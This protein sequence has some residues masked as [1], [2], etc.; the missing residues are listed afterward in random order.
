MA[1]SHLLQKIVADVPT[2]LACVYAYSSDLGQLELVEAY[3]SLDSQSENERII[4]EMLALSIPLLTSDHLCLTKENL[5]KT[6]FE[7]GIAFPLMLAGDLV[8]IMGV[9]SERAGTYDEPE[10]KQLR[11]WLPLVESML[12]NRRMRED[13]VIAQAIQH[14][15]QRIGEHPDPQDLVEILQEYMCGPHICTCVVMF[16]GP[17]REDRPNG[18]FDYL[19]VRGSWSR[20]AGNANGLGMKIYLDA[21]PDFVSQLDEQKVIITQVHEGM[22]N[23]YDP[24]IRAFLRVQNIHTT[25]SI[26]LHAGQRRMGSIF[27]ATD[28]PYQFLSREIRGYQMVSEFVSMS[29]MAHILQQQ[30]DFVQRGRAALLDAVTDGVMM[31]LPNEVIAH[32]SDSSHVL[33]VNLGFTRMFK[34]NQ[35]KA[36]GLSVPQIMELMQIPQDVRHDLY[37]Q[38]SSIPLR[39]PL[40]QRGEFNMVHPDG[41]PAS[42][43]W[44]SAPVHHDNRVM[45]RMYIFHDASASRTAANLRANFVS[46]VS[47]ELRTPLT[48]IRGFAEFML[49][50]LGD[51]LPDLAR[52]YT[53]IILNSARHLNALFSEVIEITRADTGEMNLH[54]TSTHLPDLIINVVALLELSYK[55][56]GQSIVM[57]LDDDA[58]PVL[59]DENRIAQVLTNLVNN[60]INYTPPD[61]RIR[62]RMDTISSPTQ[63]PNGTPPDV[64]IPAIMV[65]VSDE[66]PG[67][68]QEDAEQVFMPFYRTK[69]ARVGFVEGSG[70]GLTVSRSIIE[71]HRGKIWA[72]PRKR[73]RRGARFIFTLP[74]IES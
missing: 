65:T 2:D 35:A 34:M 64:V 1:L 26:A 39:D 59:V 40:V 5:Q 70:L 44:Y 60:A 67:L 17:V 63:L 73:G 24:L 72:D 25:M 68:S 48:S 46:R 19:E 18:P 43:E 9:F 14:V 57:E 6:H 4:E 56:R 69:D 29:T 51:E 47:H 32:S 30:H 28:V 71:L 52:E 42:I 21:Y 12:E 7:C 62:I 23:Q 22:M 37:A 36:Q 13:Q 53:E 58:P 55:E 31:V 41:F 20:F 11:S 33:T 54:L 16:Y 10:C 38:W 74:T 45:G 3:P 50:E 49:E 15:A 27:F 8:G 61:T 66:G